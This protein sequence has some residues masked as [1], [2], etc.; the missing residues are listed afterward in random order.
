MIVC[1]QTL[2]RVA[3]SLIP[4]KFAAL[5]RFVKRSVDREYDEYGHDSHASVQYCNVAMLGPSRADR[6]C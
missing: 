4:T 6:T 1:Q 3:D 2:S 5:I